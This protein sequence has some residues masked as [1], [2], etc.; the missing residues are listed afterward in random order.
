MLFRLPKQLHVFCLP[1]P[2][3]MQMKGCGTCQGCGHSA[4]PGPGRAQGWRESPGTDPIALTAEPC[5]HR[6]AISFGLRISHGLFSS[7]PFFSSFPP[8]PDQLSASLCPPSLCELQGEKRTNLENPTML[9]IQSKS[10]S[11]MLAEICSLICSEFDHLV[12]LL[13]LDSDHGML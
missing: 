2:A 13:F 8:I 12:W 4:S 3:R 6:K 1:E 7:F 9:R 11:S 5:I 10:C